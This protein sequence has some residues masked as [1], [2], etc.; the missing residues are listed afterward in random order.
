MGF[1]SL[2]YTRQHGRLGRLGHFWIHLGRRE[3]WVSALGADW[4]CPAAVYRRPLR[5]G[6]LL[7]N[8]IP[9]DSN[10]DDSRLGGAK[11][12]KDS[13]THDVLDPTSLWRN[14]RG[15]GCRLLWAWN[16]QHS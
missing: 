4:D 7:A 16:R 14:T 10:R 12:G 5:M 2:D 11:G 6:Y 1:W 13:W 15:R 8:R 9:G 3:E